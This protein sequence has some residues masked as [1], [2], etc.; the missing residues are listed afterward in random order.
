MHAQT[1]QKHVRIRSKNACTCK[2]TL[3][4]ESKSDAMDHACRMI[5]QPT[6]YK[7]QI[8]NA[9][10]FVRSLHCQEIST[11]SVQRAVSPLHRTASS[12]RLRH[13]AQGSLR[14]FKTK[15]GLPPHLPNN[16]QQHGINKQKAAHSKA[17]RHNSG[18]T[19]RKARGVAA[20]AKRMHTG[21]F[22]FTKRWWRLKIKN[23]QRR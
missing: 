9:R 12:K 6:T 1:R 15:S 23:A 7:L 10:A 2:R 3:E 19:A 11:R 14:L 5:C 22:T 17:S 16:P 20:A 8:F 4:S 18:R 21:H 13:T